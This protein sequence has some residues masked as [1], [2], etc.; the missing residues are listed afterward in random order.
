MC[1]CQRT[2]CKSLFPSFTMSWELW[3]SSSG[4]QAQ[5]QA[6]LPSEPSCRSRY[7]F[8][9]ITSLISFSFIFIVYVFI[10]NIE[11]CYLLKKNFILYFKCTCACAIYTCVRV[12]MCA[13]TCVRIWM[14]VSMDARLVRFPR[15]RVTD[16]C[17]PL[18][19]I[20][21]TEV[22]FSLRAINTQQPSS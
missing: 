20:L 9:M 21:G 7:F 8:L 11:K 14:Q 6:L 17:E 22:G 2:T 4:Y 1:L 12:Y 16:G 15:A 10:S 18:T 13:L 5:W 19:R 3:K